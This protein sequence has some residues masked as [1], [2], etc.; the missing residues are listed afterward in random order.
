MSGSPA[1]DASEWLRAITAFQ[2]LPEMLRTLRELKKRE[3]K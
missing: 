3:Q 1:F 2:K